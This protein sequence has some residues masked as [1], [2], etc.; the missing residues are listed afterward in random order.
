M[1]T[2]KK[3]YVRRKNSIFIFETLLIQNSI[4]CF[5]SGAFL[6]VFYAKTKENNG[7]EGGVPLCIQNPWESK[8]KRQKKKLLKKK[9]KSLLFSDLNSST[10][11]LSI[12]FFYFCDMKIN[13]NESELQHG[14]DWWMSLR[15]EFIQT[16]CETF[17]QKT[18]EFIAWISW[19]L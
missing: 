11:L 9:E 2:N 4:T 13:K 8:Q 5:D 16:E 3:K 19:Q 15:H 17:S 6:R 12:L 7:M 1:P 10:S 18:L 14:A